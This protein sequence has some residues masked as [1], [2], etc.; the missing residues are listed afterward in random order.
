[1]IET[2]RKILEAMERVLKTVEGAYKI[3]LSYTLKLMHCSFSSK[4]LRRI[5]ANDILSGITEKLLDGRR[6]WDSEKYPDFY[7]FMFLVIKSEVSNLAKQ[8][9]KLV[10]NYF[11]KISDRADELERRSEFDFLSK[12][13]LRQKNEIADNEINDKKF[14]LVDACNDVLHGQDEALVFECILDE[15][16]PRHIAE[17][18]NWEVSKVNVIMKRIK[19]KV[20]PIIFDYYRK[21]K[22]TPPT[23]I[24]RLW[25]YSVK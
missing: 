18:L 9:D 22:I 11:E 17:I 8:K 13:E 12:Y 10:Y 4:D 20:V 3:W 19:R 7:K 2:P 1:M 6:K 24:A 21:E 16:K 23:K 25:A 14:S 5:N 15:M